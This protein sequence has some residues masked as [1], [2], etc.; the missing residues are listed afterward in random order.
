MSSP[1]HSFLCQLNPY[2]VIRVIS[3]GQGV[4]IDSFSMNPKTLIC[5]KCGHEGYF[6]IE[7]YQWIDWEPH[8]IT[9]EPNHEPEWGAESTC[10]CPECNYQGYVLNFIEGGQQKKGGEAHADFS[11]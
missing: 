10:C 7:A 4:L 8:E 3:D 1:K 6:R 5:P 11:N 2:E 9:M